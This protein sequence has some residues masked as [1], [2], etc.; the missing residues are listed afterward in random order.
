MLTAK[1][2]L[3]SKAGVGIAI[4]P[5]ERWSLLDPDVLAWLVHIGS[6]GLVGALIELRAG[7][8]PAAAAL[9]A[10]R[11]S[12]RQVQ[13][14]GVAVSR[15]DTCGDG[16]VLAAATD[17]HLVLL[18]ASCNTL[19]ARLAEAVAASLALLC[20]LRGC[21]AYREA[22]SPS[23]YR[24]LLGAVERREA[25][26]ACDVASGIVARSAALA[27]AASRGSDAGAVE[28]IRE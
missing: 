18:D 25:K 14:L 22:V 11:R 23:L 3:V 27:A 17:C 21:G 26:A 16:S 7:V 15:L 28:T 20:L 13:R 1:G 8:D 4:N 19:Y 5:M 10:T 12:P 24:D 9:A 2:L 6:A